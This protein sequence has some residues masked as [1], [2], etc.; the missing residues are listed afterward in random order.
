M[1]YKTTQTQVQILLTLQG[2]GLAKEDNT[3]LCFL[4][5]LEGFPLFFPPP[6]H[7]FFPVVANSIWLWRH[8]S[9]IFNITGNSHYRGLQH[10]GTW[11][12]LTPQATC[13][14]NISL[15]YSNISLQV[16]QQ[17]YMWIQTFYI[18]PLWHGISNSACEFH[19]GA[20]SSYKALFAFL[21]I[22]V[23]FSAGEQY[24]WIR[25]ICNPASILK[26]A[27]WK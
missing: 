23:P 9:C 13:T 18:S 24:L 19:W 10:F 5:I 11:P 27:S 22:N 2:S 8:Y 7:L 6:L 17:W 4:L 21:A 16:T 26:Q 25:P 1:A 20:R 12:L 3:G 15:Q 14:A